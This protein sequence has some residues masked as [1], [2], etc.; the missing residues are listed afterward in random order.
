MFHVRI[1]LAKTKD[2]MTCSNCDSCSCGPKKLSMTVFSR[3]VGS[4]FYTEL[5]VAAGID[6]GIDVK[7]KHDADVVLEFYKSFDG[8]PKQTDAF[9][10]LWPTG[11][12]C[13]DLVSLVNISQKVN[14]ARL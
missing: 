2:I 12:V 5:F 6:L 4:N 9:A 14:D 10:V 13:I 7:V 1:S 8:T 3:V 11:Q